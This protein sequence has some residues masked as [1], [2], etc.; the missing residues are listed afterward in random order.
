MLS[1]KRYLTRSS[2][3][4][5]FLIF[6]FTNLSGAN[7]LRASDGD[8]QSYLLAPSE[9]DLFPVAVIRA[10]AD[11][12]IIENPSALLTTGQQSLHFVRKPGSN[13]FIIVDFGKNLMGH[14]RARTANVIPGGRT[15]TANVYPAQA[16]LAF[17]ESLAFLT[18]Q[19]DFSWQENHTY[20]WQPD[21]DSSDFETG[22]VTFRYVMFYLA[23]DGSLDLN[24]LRV[25]FSPFVGV[26]GTYNGWFNSSDEELNKIW[27]AAMYTLE[28]N[29]NLPEFRPFEVINGAGRVSGPSLS[30]KFNNQS[31]VIR[32]NK[33]TNWS[34]Y[35]FELDFKT[36]DQGKA[37]GWLFHSNG[38]AD[39][40]MWQI[41]KAGDTGNFTLREHLLQGGNYTLLTEIPLTLPDSSV[42]NWQKVA[43][44]LEGAS[45]RTY[46][47]GTLVDDRK[48]DTF[49]SGAVGFREA[50]G[51]WADFDNLKVSD[52]KGQTLLAENF[53]GGLENWDFKSQ[54][55]FI[56]DGAKRDRSVWSADLA[57]EAKL[58]YLSHNRPGPVHDS[59]DLLAQKQ[60]PD[61]LIPPS[62]FD[63]FNQTLYD[64]GAWWVIAL[65]DYYN[66]TGD[67]AFALRLF[68][69]L[70]KQLDWLLGR[71]NPNGL[72]VK[73]AGL[74]WSWTL[75]RQGEVTYLNLIYYQALISAG[76]LAQT[77]DQNDSATRWLQS[78]EK[79]KA[80]I[81]NR[82]FD[83]NRGLYIN[84]DTDRDRVPQ[85]ANVL[86][87]Q[88]GVAPPD[89]W[90]GILDYL[91][92]TT[93]TPFGSTTVD[94][95]Y[96]GKPNRIFP[97]MGYFEVQAR[98]LAGRDPEALDLIRREWGNMLKHDPQ[99]T[100]WEWV[101][102]DGTAEDGSNSLAHGWSGGV[103]ASLTEWV[104]GIRQ[105]APL[106]SQFSFVPHPSGL[107]WASG[108]IPT[109]LGP[110]DASWSKTNSG[111]EDR[112]T[113][114]SGSQATLGVPLSGKPVQ[115][116]VND[117][118]VWDGSQGLLFNAH[119][120]GAY[121]YL[122]LGPG[123]YSLRSQE[124]G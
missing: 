27:F 108:R 33:G 15:G 62:N 51:E 58:E 111:M 72:L 110:I 99:S 103:A 29:T 57:I 55:G 28:L 66:N 112:L 50:P 56:W 114:P 42:Q 59:L 8:W 17:S 101:N 34:D 20:N 96:P 43:I 26:A 4:I 63:N 46:V 49:G 93:W 36:P 82:L 116:F 37:A 120:E 13:P 52:L 16:R 77:L 124:S 60:R 31:L 71:L 75:P 98:F 10:E 91:K 6:T 81:N 47:N 18:P 95:P 92:Q 53:G 5:F 12:G 32:S 107:N 44:Q 3:V 85:D 88:F 70:Q 100:F 79:L 73:D 119:S 69:N 84:S 97:F 2:L 68:P 21:N 104:L 80:A 105:V 40:Y 117:S 83:S 25:H 61:G 102:P 1:P 41:A 14:L 65:A 11:G 23:T 48:D 38:P 123:S 121:L 54:P 106:Y 115:V 78:A 113:V 67:R 24:F 109:P 89:K 30:D 22:L 87:I 90:N 19:S 39:G 35:R 94:L 7:P 86:A 64:Y 74:E 122:Q 9:R 45:V 76:R 118:L